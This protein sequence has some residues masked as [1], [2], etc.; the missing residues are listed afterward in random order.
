MTTSHW[1]SLEPEAQR[2]LQLA[3]L[4]SFLRDQVVPYHP[5][6]RELFANQGIDPAA[7]GSLADFARVPLSHKGDVAPTDDDP[8]RPRHFVLQPTPESL[9][10][11]LPLG[12]KLELLWSKWRHGA[13]HVK[14]Q[15][16]AEYRPVQAFFTTGR[17]ALPTSFFLSGYDM[18]LLRLVGRR[19][20][21]VA[22]VD[23]AEDRILSVFPYAPHLAFWQVQEVGIGSGTFILQ[24]GGG[25]VMGTPAILRALSKV[26]P[27]IVAG[28]PGYVYHMFREGAEQG[29][30]LSCVRRVFLGGDRVA[31]GYRAKLID[32]LKESGAS[33]PK[34]LSV[35][36]FTESRKCW[37]ECPG[38]EEFGF[39]TYPDL[40]LFEVIDPDT[41]E[42]LPDG[43]TGELV[44][45]PLDG[46]ASIVL[47]YRTGD[48]CEGGITRERC[49]GCGRTVPRFSSNLSRQSNQKDFELTKIKGALVNLNALGDLLNGESTIEEWQ[50]I[51]R[52]RND[53][54]FDTDEMVVVVAMRNEVDLEPDEVQ[55]IVAALQRKVE[56]GCEIRPA[57]E[58]VS[59]ADL[60]ERLGM[61]TQLKELRVVDLRHNAGGPRESEV[62]K[63]DSQS[64]A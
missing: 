30:D 52:K 11:H 36:G 49:P 39:H 31:P 28:I 55:T 1:H 57:V 64:G 34:V 44:Y 40:D 58:V 41:G 48:I 56:A 33:D 17:T 19:I 46:R 60:L 12:R 23:P 8:Q 2:R 13:A 24:T 6:Y 9:R 42:V 7:F 10:A 3:K 35:Y 32:L 53:D 27:S 20:A 29:I 63:A 47:R 26:R 25:K 61:E 15:I 54:P 16:G 37:S 38:G 14:Q 59:R 43:E 22:T 50:I 62:V 18:E 45:T 21:E 4:R 51:I 5:F